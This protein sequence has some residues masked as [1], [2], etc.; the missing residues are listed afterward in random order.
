MPFL[1][2]VRKPHGAQIRRQQILPVR[3]QLLHVAPLIRATWLAGVAHEFRGARHSL[4]R[5]STG[6]LIQCR[7]QPH[8]SGSSTPVRWIVVTSRIAYLGPPGTFSEEAAR[9][10]ADLAAAEHIAVTTIPE[11]I[12]AVEE[13]AASL[14]VVPLENAIEGSITTTLDTLGFE[15][16]LLIQREIELPVHF[17][18]AGRDGMQLG[19]VQRVL[20]FSA[21]YAQCRQWITR[22]MPGVEVVHAAS[23][24]AAAKSA[25]AARRS[26]VAAITN[27]AAMERYGLTRIAKDVADHKGNVT[28]FALIGRSIPEPTGHDKTS[29]VCFQR[30]DRPGSLLA[31]LSEFASRAINL[32]M[33]TSRPTKNGLGDYCFFIDVEGHIA[34]PL[35]A[36]CLRSL[37]ARSAQVKFLGSYPVVGSAHHHARRHA[38]TKSWRNAQRWIDGLQAQVGVSTSDD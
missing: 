23:N 25:A 34:D 8:R 17:H 16:E 6:A 38:T 20:A 33:I 18:L 36:D 4:L 28:R 5:Q 11:V 22:R 7:A 14:G 9:S 3:P 24:A 10:Q 37:A 15:S 30:H 32:T 2:D 12:S 27:T 1:V 35:L 21:S 19:D 31:M 26:G 29:I 13:G